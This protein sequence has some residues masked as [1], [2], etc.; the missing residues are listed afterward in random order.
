MARRLRIESAGPLYHVTAR[1]DER[2]DIF[3]G[4]AAD[5]R[6]S[7]LGV[8]AE[9]C[10]RFNWMCHAYCLMSNHYRLVVETPDANLSKGMSHYN[11]TYTTTRPTRSWSTAATGGWAICFRAVSRA[12]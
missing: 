5:D 10:D 4:N 6:H 11:E 1:D 9:T 2:R 8:L 7:F 3:L 12:S